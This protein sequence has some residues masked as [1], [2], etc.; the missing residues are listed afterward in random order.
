MAAELAIVDKHTEEAFRANQGQKGELRLRFAVKNGKTI[1]VDRFHANTLKV[2]K[3]FY[4]EKGTGRVRLTQV[5][6]GGG[7]FRGDR[8]NQ[9]YVLDAGAKV[10][11]TA[12]SSTK[13]YKSPFGRSEQVSHFQL[14]ADSE[15]EY[16]TY[17]TIPFADS[18]FKSEMNIELSKGRKAFFTEIVSPGRWTRGEVFKYASYQSIVKAYWEGQLILWDNWHIIPS[19]MDINSLGFY[20]GYT[21]Q[22]S[23]YIFS[24][25]ALINQDM[26]TTI[27][28]GLAERASVLAGA[29]IMAKGKGI[30]VRLLGNRGGDL[31]QAADDVWG[32]I[33]CELFGSPKPSM[34]QY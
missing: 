22:G 25:G 3:P 30:I 24:D 27:H 13:V 29:T 18:H 26:V 19:E 4:L 21:H 10:L 17:A 14:A 32:M 20:E 9:H 16:I 15:L 8:L 6:I 23:V 7:I 34:R 12:Q 28:E 11:L 31:E 5:S 1:I 2:C 33:R